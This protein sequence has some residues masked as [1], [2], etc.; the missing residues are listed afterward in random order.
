MANCGHC[1]QRTGGPEWKAR[2]HTLWANQFGECV[3]VFCDVCGAVTDHR[4]M[5]KVYR[6]RYATGFEG[7]DTRWRVEGG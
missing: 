1:Q 7:K 4:H 5:D 2:Q 6:W 3:R